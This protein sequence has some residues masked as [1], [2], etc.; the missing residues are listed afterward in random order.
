MC[1]FCSIRSLSFSAVFVT[2][3]LNSVD[4]A[5]TENSIDDSGIGNGLFSAV[6]GVNATVQLTGGVLDGA[7]N[8]MLVASVSTP[9]PYLQSLGF[10]LDLAIGQYDGVAGSDS[11]AAAGHLF[12]RNPEMG[13]LGAYADYGVINSFHFGR[14]GFEGSK[15]IGSWSVDVLLGMEFGQ[16]VLTRFVDEVDISY[17]FNENFKVSIGHRL[18]SRGHMGN[19]GFEKQFY[20]T[21]NVAWSVTGLAE[22][23]EDSFTQAF[24]GLKAT[25]G[26]NG[27]TTLQQR[28]RSRSVKVRIPRN[29]ASIT[30]CGNVDAPFRD[31][32]WMYDVGL[33]SQLN[34]T[35][36][37]SKTGIRKRS[38]TAIFNP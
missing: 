22:A 8:G 38:S 24:L 9:L 3:S 4:I 15:Y 36:C 28:D 16:N 21:E 37:A 26:R 14:I 35:H 1:I 25:F 2:A 31:P 5:H 11:G 6:D 12:W 29:L 19:V 34:T 27:A 23:G 10:Q 33:V 13:M 7:A 32:Q 18:T 17:N 20:A 30:Q